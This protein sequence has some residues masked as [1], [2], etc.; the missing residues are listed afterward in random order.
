MKELV[1]KQAL[2]IDVSKASLSMC[3]G[4]MNGQ[5]EKNF[6]PRTDVT[7]DLSGFKELSKWLKKVSAGEVSPIVVLE[8]TGVYHEGISL[9]LHGLGYAVSIMQS[10]RVKRYAQ[11]LDQRS[12]TDALDSKMLSMLGC[13][14]EL[15]VWSPP[16]ALMQELK[17][18][19]RERSTL[20]K[21]KCIDGNRQSALNS[22]AYSSKKEV[23]R[24][25]QRLKLLV[26]QINDV[27]QEMRDLVH[28][29]PGL[30]EKMG[31]LESIPGVSFICGITVVSE[32]SGFDLI[33]NAKQLTSYAGYDIVMKESGTYRGKTRISKKG[34]S[35]IRA[36]IHMPSMT[37]IRVNPTRKPFYERLKPRKVKPLIAL[38]AVQR[39]MLILM[40]TLWK[41]GEYYD[42]EFE[43]K[44]VASLQETCYTG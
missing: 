40:Y 28:S 3:L 16:S 25:N 6:I 38:V 24:Y 30:T 21:Q 42:G 37:A 22:S 11:S 19:S 23:K 26:S 33:N 39:K 29:D 18:M 20:I 36:V 14:R 27:E 34:N 8:A 43:Q 4:V 44:K 17:A 15:S 35:H 41:K 10:G 31:Y 9:Y 5:L 2:G 12:K 7:N 32:T 13:E 1:L